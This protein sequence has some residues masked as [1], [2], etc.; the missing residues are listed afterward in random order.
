MAEGEVG[1]SWGGLGV[2][3]AE[4]NMTRY[5]NLNC[6]QSGGSWASLHKFI[7]QDSLSYSGH[8]LGDLMV[9]CA[10]CT[11]AEWFE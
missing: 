5:L 8:G 9:P 3:H 1:T 7:W 2:L 6:I 4:G 10:G 11:L